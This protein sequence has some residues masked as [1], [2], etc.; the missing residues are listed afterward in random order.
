MRLISTD[1]LKEGMQ[2][3]EA[4]YD[5]YNRLLLGR[6]ATIQGTYLTRL[7][8]MGLPALYVQDDDTADIYVPQVIPPAARIKAIQS[9]T[10]TFGS[11][12]K[13][14]ENFRQV[15]TEATRQN[16]QSGKFM[17]T[18]NSL[19]HEEGIDQLVGDVNTFIDQLMDREVLIGL[20]SIKT[21]DNYTFQHSIDVTIMGLLLAR[22]IGWNQKRLRAFGIGC[23]L[24]DIGKIFIDPEI[25]T[26]PDRLNEDEFEWMK[27][28]P[29]MGYELLKVIAPN[30]GYLGPNV[31]YQ[32]HERQDGSGYPRGLKGDNTLGENT[33]NTIHDF[34]AVA[35]VADI[36]DAMASDRPY[37]AGWPPD[38][39]VGLIRDLSGTHLNS[40]VV[41]VFLKTVAPYPIG[42]G[43]KV[44]NGKYKG[45]KGVVA[46][47]DE[48]ILDRP[49]VR[50]LFDSQGTRVDAVELDLQVEGDITVASVR[51]GEPTLEPLGSSTW[52]SISSDE[53]V[54]CP[55]CGQRSSGNFCPDCGTSLKAKSKESVGASKKILIA[56]DSVATRRALSVLIKNMGYIPI[57]AINGGEA[58]KLTRQELPGMIILDIVMPE[59]DGLEALKRIRQEE[60]TANIP[61]VMLTSLPDSETVAE[62]IQ[63]GANDYVMKPFK[64]TLIVDRIGRYMPEEGQ[65]LRKAC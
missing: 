44:L 38:R 11:L 15:S 49:Q 17:D 54:G 33:P 59:M 48:T 57:E 27:A 55:S 12:S 56:E 13:S 37:R 43:V 23:I 1:N 25:L 62:A 61:V 3:G 45:Y 64:A 2:A 4:I 21:H 63:I 22:K 7:K 8:G 24:H 65:S 20:N 16:I 30:F 52:V 31:A 10:D 50:L 36:Y 47:V 26:K 35:A 28:H 53:G 39:V 41:E 51:S 32:H 14:V 6:G 29:T 58:V 5:E 46:D 40:R 19:S 42:T 34:G 60:G 18:F 9:L